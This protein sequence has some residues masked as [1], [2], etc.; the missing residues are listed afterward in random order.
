[1]TSR[2]PKTSKH[3]IDQWA[4]I[5]RFRW[6]RY[7]FGLVGLFS[8]ARIIRSADIVHTSAFVSSVYGFLFAWIWAK[9][10]VLTIHEIFGKRWIQFFWPRG[11]LGYVGEKIMLRLP[12]DAR[13][14][15]SVFTQKQMPSSM[16]SLCV[17]NGIDEARWDPRRV[18]TSC[19]DDM[20]ASLGIKGKHILLYF[21]RAGKTKGLEVMM[22]AMKK[23]LPKH[24]SYVCVAIL[25]EAS[26]RHYRRYSR[27]HPQIH[28][29]WQ[30]SL[31][32]LQS[33]IVR[34]S[35]VIVPSLS[36]GFGFSALQT[37]YL[38]AQ[39]ITSDAW[40]LPDVV[41]G[42]VYIFASG[43]SM[44]LLEALENKVLGRSTR[45]PRR[46]FPVEKMVS[47]YESIYD[48]L[49]SDSKDP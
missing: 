27:R 45:I 44:S 41:N 6:G 18:D 30:Q 29:L 16:S 17:T 5:Y 3:Q 28:V 20:V 22:E 10:S 26:H 14:C 8:I 9:K 25:P 1:M 7:F 34:S 15:V 19:V 38:G 13:V 23:F 37:S 4:H 24:P 32:C 42:D 33:W 2:L 21:G 36:E 49:L 43:S 40:A 39:I 47:E 46:S 31:E 48:S 11:W 35:A 12:F